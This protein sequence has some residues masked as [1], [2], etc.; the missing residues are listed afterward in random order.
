MSRNEKQRMGISEIEELLELRFQGKTAF[1][2]GELNM[3]EAG[4]KKWFERGKGPKGPAEI[5]MRQWLA[6]ARARKEQAR[7]S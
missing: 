4:V 3:S 7:A 6:E 1:L 2:A 5:L